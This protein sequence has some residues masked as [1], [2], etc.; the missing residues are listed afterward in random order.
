MESYANAI[1]VNSL[2]FE[3]PHSSKPVLNGI[4]LSIPKGEFFVLTGPSGSGKSTLAFAILGIISKKF[5]GL[6]SGQ[7]RIFGKNIKEFEATDI[8]EII[9]MV[10]QDPN[11]QFISLRIREE[12]LLGLNLSKFTKRQ[13]EEK[14]DYYLHLVGLDG[15]SFRSPKEISAGQKQKI[16]IASILIKEPE[17]IVLDEPL[18]MLDPSS[19][20]SIVEILERLKQE[21]KTIVIIAHDVENILHLADRVGVLVDGKIIEIGEPREVIY[22]DNFLKYEQLPLS[23]ELIKSSD[24]ECKPVTIQ[25]VISENQKIRI[26]PVESPL[27][28]GEVILQ[29][30]NV[31]YTYPNGYMALE[32]VNLKIRSGEYIAI[33]GTNGSGKSTLALLA[34]GILKPSKGKVLIKGQDSRK[35]DPKYLSSIIGLIFQNPRDAL[36]EETVFKEVIFGPKA[37][38]MADPEMATNGALNLVEMED[39]K[40]SNPFNLSYGQQ[41]KNRNCIYS[42]T[43]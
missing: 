3:F 8:S 42:R 12:L 27:Q 20:K 17:I 18:S 4:D 5:S 11:S 26:D 35:L 19:Q 43:K 15:Y 13:L 14:V 7:I 25:E 38:K 37:L 39:L 28:I 36:F 34:N 22:S 2:F 9:G 23:L 30:Q 1:E 10:F 32:N 33:V 40:N 31:N 24:P 29:F 16:A 6:F 21:G 41:K